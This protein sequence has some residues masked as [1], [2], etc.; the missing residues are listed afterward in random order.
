MARHECLW[1]RTTVEAN[2]DFRRYR[3]RGWTVVSYSLYGTTGSPLHAFVW[4][5]TPFGAAEQMT[6]SPR[7]YAQFLERADELAAE[8]FYLSHVGAIGDV[9]QLGSAGGGTVGEPGA[10]ARFSGIFARRRSLALGE[11]GALGT[12]LRGLKPKFVAPRAWYRHQED[13]FQIAI[14][15]PGYYVRSC[16]VLGTPTHRDFRDA[17]VRFADSN[18]AADQ[19]TQRGLLMYACLWPLPEKQFA[20]S[21]DLTP[22]LR[23]RHR[24]DDQVIEP[25]DWTE[26]WETKVLA[27]QTH[28]RAVHRTRPGYYVGNSTLTLSLWYDERYSWW[29]EPDPFSISV[30]S[31]KVQTVPG[32]SM[33]STIMNAREGGDQRPLSITA[34]GSGDD[35]RFTVTFGRFGSE[36]PLPRSWVVRGPGS[37]SGTFVPAADQLPSELDLSQAPEL[38]RALPPEPAEEFPW[39][40]QELERGRL[41]LSL[42]PVSPGDAAPSGLRGGTPRG[43][44]IG[45]APVPFG[46][47]SWPV[48]EAKPPR[49]P[50]PRAPSLR[51]DS[52][53]RK[54]METSGSRHGQLVV[55]RRGRLVHAKAYTW[56]EQGYPVCTLDHAMRLASVSKALTAI[57][58]IKYVI[59]ELDQGLGTT[60]THPSLLNISAGLGHP[61]LQEVTL[62]HLLTHNAGWVDLGRELNGSTP[63]APRAILEAVAGQ[64]SRENILPGELSQYLRVL[65]E[66]YYQWDPGT[67]CALDYNN[68]GFIILG[69][70]V[71]RTL[72]GNFSEY[73]QACRDTMMPAVGVTPDRGGVL[74][75]GTYRQARER[76]ESP[77]QSTV[78]RAA[79][80]PFQ[81]LDPS[82]PEKVS[83]VYTW[84]GPF[85]GGA[86]GWAV[87]AHWVARILASLCPRP[88]RESF[89]STYQL[90]VWAHRVACAGA[91]TANGSYVYQRNFHW[92]QQPG[93]P[94]ESVL[95]AYH[96]GIMDGA[97]TLMGHQ[98]PAAYVP[99]D[100]SNALSFFVALNQ[101]G[102]GQILEDY[103]E[104][105]EIFGILQD[106]ERTTPFGPEDLFDAIP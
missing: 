64:T 55:V 89:L 76:K 71:S 63:F 48:P 54:E 37:P 30:S 65:T 81:P 88:G 91:E 58:V 1:D 52:W 9:I 69:E 82:E 2:E 7:P 10:N 23:N 6:T 38:P 17:G 15:E 42:D 16:G 68:L 5:T 72:R 93:A 98:F 80:N 77:A 67:P 39:T 34:L 31:F 79:W 101:G 97:V 61:L 27:T 44:P 70:L 105:E 33:F 28:P 41:D 4:D 85:F 13:T 20:W 22:N 45:E 102:K 50:L 78:P 73:D 21:V 26:R 40:V 24:D 29:P 59:P 32:A 104:G 35:K 74:F 47:D 66:D 103:R 95:R 3:D 100:P 62:R 87:P 106:I 49:P 96:N 53:M 83:P 60:V 99:A 90:H 36:S 43:G 19:E 92:V 84:D 86:G 11:A 56:A 25:L 94:V 57:N 51:L 12:H 18:A 14:R 46:T 8:G 75:G